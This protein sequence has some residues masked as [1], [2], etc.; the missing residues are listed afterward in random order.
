MDE[1]I[2]LPKHILLIKNYQ[3]DNTDETKDKI[4]L[5]LDAN[6]EDIF[7]V[8]ALVTSVQ[9]LPDEKLNHGCTNSAEYS[10]Y[11]FE[12]DRIVGKMP[13]QEDFKFL[14]NTFIYV[15]ENITQIP[16]DKYNTY[17]QNSISLLGVLDNDEHKRVIKCI[18]K[19]RFLKN[20][21]KK[22][23]QSIL[24]NLT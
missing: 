4:S 19:S 16:T 2:F 22:I 7:M 14:K 17:T 1:N 8:Q 12:K 23:F 21:L 6:E 3:F 5:I 9:K 18:A 13:N 20:K 15:A 24:E 11:H 10:F